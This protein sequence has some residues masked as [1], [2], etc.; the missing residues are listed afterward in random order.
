MSTILIQSEKESGKEMV[1]KILAT[2]ILQKPMRDNPYFKVE[3]L[4]G[5]SWVVLD[6]R[7]RI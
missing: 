5:L 6:D 4:A 1:R 7:E 3:D 2:D